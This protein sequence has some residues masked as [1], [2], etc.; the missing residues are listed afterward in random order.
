MPYS[1]AETARKTIQ[2]TTNCSTTPQSLRRLWGKSSWKPFPGIQRIRKCFGATNFDSTRANRA[3]PTRLPSAMRWQT[4]WMR[5]E[6]W[7]LFTWTFNK[8]FS[9][10]ALYRWAQ[11]VAVSHWTFNWWSVISSVFQESVLGLILF[12]VVFFRDLKHG[13]GYTLRNVHRWYPIGERGQCAGGQG[14]YSEMGWQKSWQLLKGKNFL[15]QCWNTHL[16]LQ[17]LGTASLGSS[18]AEKDIEYLV[19]NKMNISAQR[20][21]VKVKANH[22]LWCVSK[23]VFSRSRE[24]VIL[25]YLVIVLLHNLGS[26]VQERFWETAAKCSG[27]PL[28]CLGGW[29]ILEVRRCWDNWICSAWRR[30]GGW[31]QGGMGI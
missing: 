13:M 23:H 21:R 10:A 18:F 29:S 22:I 4:L 30:P 25:L 26:P 1:P 7:V 5:R 31:R 11:R 16:Q 9:I 14:S 8:A 2:G 28:R 24:A 6:W 19:E 17:R 3:W 20:A 27:G 12:S 15:C